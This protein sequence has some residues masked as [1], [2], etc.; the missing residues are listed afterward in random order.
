VGKMFPCRSE[1]H[2]AKFEIEFTGA[3]VSLLSRWNNDDLR[4]VGRERGPEPV[5]IAL[6]AAIPARAQ[7]P[8]AGKKPSAAKPI[9]SS[10]CKRRPSPPPPSPRFVESRRIYLYVK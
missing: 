2:L 9:A 4:L 6:S 8:V 10:E 5:A 1:R 3:G 7:A